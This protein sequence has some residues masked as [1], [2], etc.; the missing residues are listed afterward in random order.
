MKR[1]G[2][3]ATHMNIHT[4][5]SVHA[6]TDQAWAAY[7]ADIYVG[8]GPVGRGATKEAAIADLREQSLFNAIE[9]LTLNEDL[10]CEVCASRQHIDISEP[11]AQSVMLNMREALALREWLNKVLP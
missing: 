6:P 4:E 8:S 2:S 3:Y 5:H 11:H 9:A 7:Y 1:A 10:L